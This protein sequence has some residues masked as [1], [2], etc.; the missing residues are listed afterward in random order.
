M[1]MALKRRSVDV[2]I[3]DKAAAH[4][5]KSE[6]LAIWPQSREIARSARTG[7]PL[8]RRPGGKASG[9]SHSI[10]RRMPEI[11]LI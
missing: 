8:Q 5:D 11:S 10:E 2:R 6:A 3:L 4:T 9:L 7:P 1:A